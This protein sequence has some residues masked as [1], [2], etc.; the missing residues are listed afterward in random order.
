MRDSKRLA[1]VRKLPCMR[2]GAPA[3][4]QAAHSNFAEHGKSRGRKANDCYTVPMCLKCHQWFDGYFEMTGEQSKEW[5]AQALN[6]TNQMLAAD[7]ELF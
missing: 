2:C 6:K 5:F 4:S 3:P 1:E 7:E